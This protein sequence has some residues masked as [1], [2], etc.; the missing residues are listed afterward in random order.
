[1]KDFQLALFRQDREDDPLSSC[2]ANF[3]NFQTGS[4][5]CRPSVSLLHSAT[6]KSRKIW[7]FI[8]V[9]IWIWQPAFWRCAS[10]S[11]GTGSARNTWQAEMFKW[12]KLEYFKYMYF[13]VVI[14]DLDNLNVVQI[15]SL[16]NNSTVCSWCTQGLELHPSESGAAPH[17]GFGKSTIMGF[18]I[19]YTACFYVPSPDKIKR[20]KET[21]S[22]DFRPPFF[23]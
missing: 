15:L 11:E 13:S 8:I 23:S 21:V 22:R 20:F 10:G 6:G 19:R 18:R 16:L 7:H 12:A 9:W 1:M 5:F 4:P 14:L 17:Y 2:H 3:A